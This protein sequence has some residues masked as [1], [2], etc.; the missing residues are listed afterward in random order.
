M[1]WKFLHHFLPTPPGFTHASL[2]CYWDGT[3]Y[4]SS[5]D[6][7][8]RSHIFGAYFDPRKLE[9]GKPGV[10]FSPRLNSPDAYGCSVCQVEDDEILYLG[11]GRDAEPF[12]NA[13]MKYDGSGRVVVK[14]G[15]NGAHRGEGV[16]LSL[17][18][19]WQERG[20][21]FTSAVTEWPMLCEI[22]APERVFRYSD[23]ATRPC[24]IGDEMW[25]CHR[26][27]DGQYRLAH[28]AMTGVWPVAEFQISSN[29]FDSQAQCYPSVFELFG[30]RYLLYNGDGYGKTGFGLA[31]WEA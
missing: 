7:R 13:L 16:T 24:V 17:S 3:V 21:L 26:K 8:G 27:R 23:I 18:Y 22:R 29:G 9:I 12:D 2:P 28:V 30:T 15:G 19:G 1:K 5:R 14:K 31:V 4:F 20:R 10:L 11:W 25:F 6:G